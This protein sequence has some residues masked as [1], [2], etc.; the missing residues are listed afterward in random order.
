MSLLNTLF[1]WLGVRNVIE[2]NHDCGILHDDSCINPAN[3][4]PMV[5]GCASVDVQGN[6]YGV[7]SHAWAHG[8]LDTGWQNDSW[9]NF[10]SGAGGSW[11]D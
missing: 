8:S 4:L 3:G 1:G 9:S 2:P 6:P 5:N 11:G 7:D 10:D